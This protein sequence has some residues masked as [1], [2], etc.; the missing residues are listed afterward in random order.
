MIG[1]ASEACRT[2]ASAGGRVVP[3]PGD[4]VLDPFA[5]TGT[6]GRVA[7]GLGRRAWL[8]EK[9]PTCWTKFAAFLQAASYNTA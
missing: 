9:A 3:A 8:T 7:L 5:G 2:G 4:V 6:T 1:A